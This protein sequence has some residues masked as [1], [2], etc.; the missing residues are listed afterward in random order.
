MT[1]ELTQDESL[2][3]LTAVN[4][5]IW[6]FDGQD[7]V[8]DENVYGHLLQARAQLCVQLGI[9]EEELVR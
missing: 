7:I 2:A 9:P 1:I 8:F 4:T 6:S 3:V 5:A